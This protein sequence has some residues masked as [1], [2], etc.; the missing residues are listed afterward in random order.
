MTTIRTSLTVLV[1][2]MLVLGQRTF[3]SS[4]QRAL[5]ARIGWWM[6]RHDIAT[7]GTD[8]LLASVGAERARKFSLVLAWLARVLAGRRLVVLTGD[9]QKKGGV[10]ETVRTTLPYLL[11]AGVEVV[12]RDVTTDPGARPALEF[13]HVLAH[14]RPPSERWRDVLD[15]H[16]TTFSEFGRAAAAELIP[17]LRASDIVLLCDTQTAPLIPQLTA[18]RDR[19]IWFACIGTSDQNEFVDHYWHVVGPAVSATSARVFFRAEFVPR[20]LRDRYA[21]AEPGID[22]SSAKNA[23]LDKDDARAV[24]SRNPAGGPVRWVD[25]L[26]PVPRRDDV[27]GVQLS[28][29]DPLKDMAGAC[30][31]FCR[32]AEK[33]PDFTGLVVG[34]SAQSASERAQL[35]ECVATWRAAQAGPRSRVHV[36][37]IEDCGSEAHENA[38]R[39]IQSAADIVVQKSVQEGFG[40]TVTEAMMRGKPVVASAVG[41]IPLQVEDGRNGLLVEPG[42]PD[43]SWVDRLLEL[44]ADA[45]LRRRL[46]AAAQRDA[47]ERHTV[48]RYLTAVIGG[49]TSHVAA[50][51]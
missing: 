18:W 33:R 50:A 20:C 12:W 34:P 45:S 44:T 25:G 24:L 21:V 37:I 4:G 38:V 9:D 11:G 2:V 22:P 6:S 29:W 19:L 13:F 23:R 15:D 32:M 16:V 31:V 36:G 26:R 35:Q 30:H 3:K 43:E 8:R 48:D 49:V 7:Y 10:Y 41:G 39:V 5:A 17:T 46:G 42:S 51:N 28:R 47:L 40:L 14:G 27:L 1:C